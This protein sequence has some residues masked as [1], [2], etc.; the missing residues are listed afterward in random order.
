MIPIGIGPKRLKIDIPLANE[1]IGEK[2]NKSR[3]KDKMAF[4]SSF[5]R[6]FTCLLADLHPSLMPRP[7]LLMCQRTIIGPKA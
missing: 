6:R 4:C 2:L 5:L 3:L 7:S 1:A